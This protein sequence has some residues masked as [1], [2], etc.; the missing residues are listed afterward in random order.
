MYVK[1]RR[2]RMG[3]WGL[4]PQ[5]VLK[6]FLFFIFWFDLIDFLILM[7]L[8]HCPHQPFKPFGAPDVYLISSQLFVF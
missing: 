2:K 7:S 6:E 5:Q 8:G 4:V 3:R 1:G